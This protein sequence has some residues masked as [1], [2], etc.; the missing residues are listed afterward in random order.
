M[1]KIVGVGRVIRGTTLRISCWYGLLVL[2]TEGGPEGRFSSYAGENRPGVG[3]SYGLHAS[4][5][6]IAK[7]EDCIRIV[8]TAVPMYNTRSSTRSLEI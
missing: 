4:A 3:S 7:S 2:P 5:V 1:F 8:C 6:E